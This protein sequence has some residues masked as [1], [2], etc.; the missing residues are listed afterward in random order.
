MGAAAAHG[1]LHQL[2]GWTQ[3]GVWIGPGWRP[4]LFVSAKEVLNARSRR[5]RACPKEV[6]MEPACFSLTLETLGL[7]L[8]QP[9]EIAVR[10]RW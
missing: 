10:M 1:A 8:S 2:P 7:V 3:L 6:M 9:V 4:H 5:P